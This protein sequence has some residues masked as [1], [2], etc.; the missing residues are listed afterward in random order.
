M[1]FV[2]NNAELA[3]LS[4]QDGEDA[5]S[6]RPK[7][8]A[9]CRP[10][11]FWA[12]NLLIVLG[13]SEIV[14]LDSRD[15]G[16]V[17]WRC[18]LRAN[19]QPPQYAQIPAERIVSVSPDAQRVVVTYPTGIVSVLDATNGN[20]LWFIQVEGQLGGATCV[21]DG[22]LAVCAGNPLNVTL[23][24]IDTQARRNVIPISGGVTAEPVISGDRLYIADHSNKLRAF[25]CSTGK[26]L[27][28]QDCGTEI[29]NLAATRELVFAHTPGTA[30]KRI[31]AYKTQADGNNRAAWW[32]DIDGNVM[33]M[34]VDADD[35]YV[36]VNETA[37]LGSGRETMLRA[38]RI[39][40]DGKF[41]W[42]TDIS[43]NFAGAL[44]SYESI[45]TAN[46]IVL[47]QSNWDP[48]GQQASHIVLVDRHTGKRSWDEPLA[49]DATLTADGTHV[50]FTVQ[51]FDGGVA[52]SE[53]KHR[54]C[55]VATP[56]DPAENDEKSINERYE[57]NPDD[58]DAALRW[59]RAQYEKGDH[60]K[61]LGALEKALGSASDEKFAKVY[62]AYAKMRQHDAPKNKAVLK[63]AKLDKAPKLDGNLDDWKSVAEQ[64][65][66]SWRDVYLASESVPGAPAKKG[67]WK[68]ASDLSATFRGGYDDKNLY[69]LLAV[70]DDQQKNDQ[71]EAQLIDLGDSVTLM[72]DA[73]NDGG[74]AYIGEEFS[75]GA[76]L[77]NPA[78][79]W[80]GAG[81][82][83]V[84]S[85]P[86]RRRWKM[87]SWPATRARRPRHTN[88]R[89][90]WKR[91]R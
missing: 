52:V 29:K 7:L 56:A 18:R 53:A 38:Y 35:L 3:V 33:D 76:G 25:D 91:W 37:E 79:P 8:P 87:F 16:K 49:S 55:F 27:W 59:A 54:T 88:L 71:T 85:S 70:T 22:C 31:R 44:S 84:N 36:V 51:V 90:R 20:E 65:F 17:A 58:A 80:A 82:S 14:A 57:K 72:F 61:A 12:D 19:L 39:S 89:F 74:S 28:E 68:G 10:V 11:G 78:R 45:L 83:T 66:D 5:W 47:T 46:H 81:W 26:L 40:T 42:K 67:V 86:E 13:D 4:G 21:G 15:K 24:D 1:F 30:D 34:R 75:L 63:F 77:R 2:E 48:T 41:Q 73:N 62:D 64:K 6:P 43:Q 50:T 32:L 60:A 69:V 9:G 23:Y